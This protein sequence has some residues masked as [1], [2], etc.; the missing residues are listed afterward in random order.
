MLIADKV[1]KCHQFKS[2]F[3]HIFSDLLKVS[4]LNGIC[5]ICFANY[6]NTVL[7]KVFVLFLFVF[8]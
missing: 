6:L 5:T 2:H 7:M 3:F 8:F 1:L 4:S